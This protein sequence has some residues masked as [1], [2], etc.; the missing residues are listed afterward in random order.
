MAGVHTIMDSGSGGTLVTVECHLSNSLPNII[1]VGFAQRAVEEAKE[2]IRGALSSSKIPIPRKR[3]ILNLAPA[4]LPKSGSAFDLPMLVAI[5]STA[6]L[7]PQKLNGRT[8]VLGEVG[9]DG[10]IKPIR[11]IIGKILAAKKLGV[12]NF[13]I[14]SD[15][16]EQAGLIPNINIYPFA[17]VSELYSSLLYS[18]LSAAK[19]RLPSLPKTPRRSI[20]LDNIVGQEF[21]KRA[22]VIAAAGRHNIF[23]TG[24]PGAGKTLLAKAMPGLLP[25][26]TH[27]EMLEVTHLHSLSSKKYQQIVAERPFRS[28]HHTSSITSVLGGGSLPKP[29]EISLSHHGILFMDELAE[30]NRSVIEALRQPMEDKKISVSRAN[31]V[32]QFPAD[33]ILIAAANPCACGF[34]GSNK[35]CTC[36]ASRLAQ[37][38]R[39]ISGPIL[40][41]IDLFVEVEPIPHSELLMSHNIKPVSERSLRAIHKAASIQLIRAGTLNSNLDHAQLKLFAKMSPPAEQLLNRAARNMKLSARSYLRTVKVARTIADLETSRIIQERHLA[42]ALQYRSRTLV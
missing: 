25:P 10:T 31:F 26:L 37:Y 4:D 12:E 23:L 2:R 15:N 19:M 35:P 27:E 13:W 14:P 34:Y 9:L 7:I 24:P 18:Q 20:A 6:G 33:F 3:I 39:K 5:L 28:P 38:Q 30:F 11:G 29:G 22:L 1:I 17:N 42:E 32:D 8:V 21:A 41:R 36:S 40:D 16:A